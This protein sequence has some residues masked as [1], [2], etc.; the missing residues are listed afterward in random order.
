MRCLLKK[1]LRLALHPMN[2]AFLALSALLMVPNYPYYVTFFYTSLGIFMLFQAARENHDIPYMMVLP[3]QKR[4]MVR[5][6]FLLVCAVE[7]VQLVCCIPFLYLR[8]AYAHL[9]NQVGVEANW[10]FLGL[11]MVLM[12]LF[13]L[14]FLP[15]FYRTAEKIGGPFLCSSILF[16][17]LIFAAEALEWVVPGLHTAGELA[18][19]AKPL[20]QLP[21]FAAGLAIYAA[22]SWL[23]YR[24]SA[25]RFAALDLHF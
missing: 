10:V 14:S 11:S 19:G 21:Y 2:V 15:G 17:V 12:G 7:L 20:S 16:F 23:A 8:G 5:A 25:K 4:D 22:L 18:A 6:R 13:N 3:L 1:E 24:I 9:N